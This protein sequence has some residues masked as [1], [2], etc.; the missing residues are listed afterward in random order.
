[1]ASVAI[2]F[3]TVFIWGSTWIAIKYQAGPVAPEVSV[4]YRFLAAA[5]LLFLWC[6]LR[7]LR[8]RFSLRH[9]FFMALQGLCLFC[10]NYIPIYWASK[11]LTSGLVAVAFSSV[12]LFSLLLGSLVGRK[13]IEPRVGLGALCGV[14][15]LGLIFWPEFDGLVLSDLTLMAI[16]LTL[17]GAFM[18]SSGTV[19]GSR[20]SK[21]G[22]PVVQVSAFG[23]LYGGLATAAY[24]TLLPSVSGG[25]AW[26]PAPA[27]AAALAYLVLFG[28]VVGFWGFLT[29][30][31]RLGPERASYIPVLFPVVALA[32]STLVEGY[33]WSP[34]AVIGLALVLTG[35][36]LVLMKPGSRAQK[37][38]SPNAKVGSAPV[39]TASARPA[40]SP[41]RLEA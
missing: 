3:M 33:A 10:L 18:G 32:I 24:V 7:G 26:D 1:M 9:H 38:S 20:N 22:I 15:G 12:V 31:A 19:I 37:S 27:Y 23:M 13:T 25:W 30:V 14:F 28:S 2:F 17:M 29:I 16:G 35:N 34:A 40:A 41:S 11:W 6:W 21:A 4:A 5:L 36:A 8:L 39:V